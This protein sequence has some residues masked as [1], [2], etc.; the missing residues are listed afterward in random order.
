MVIS[1][2]LYY[3]YDLNLVFDFFDDH[4]KNPCTTVHYISLF[5]FKETICSLS[6]YR[7]RG[8]ERKKKK[9]K[10]LYK[11][12]TKH[13]RISKEELNM[14]VKSTSQ[15]LDLTMIEISPRLNSTELYKQKSSPSRLR[16]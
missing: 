1:L 4:L 5:S 6:I 3:R 10:K 2:V 7:S 16:K 11:K 14:R 9:E 15:R 8:E 12:K 13:V